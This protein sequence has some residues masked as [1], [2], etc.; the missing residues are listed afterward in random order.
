MDYREQMKAAEA[1]SS[2]WSGRGSEKSDTHLFWAGFLREVL[3]VK[4]VSSVA[5]FERL[6]PDGGWID[7]LVPDARL[8]VEQKSIGRDLDIPEPRR[9]QMVTPYQQ[10]R[11]YANSLTY[12]ERVRYIITCNFGT[13]RIYDL[14]NPKHESE[15]VEIAL[16]D[17]KD[18]LPSFS[19][20]TDPANSRIE[21]ERRVS[22]QAG[23]LIGKLYDLL[24]SQYHDPDSDET[25]HALNALC[26]R[27]VFCL[28]AEDSG[29]FG[30]KAMFADYLQGFQAGQMR[31]ALLELFKTLNTPEDERD[32]Y[33]SDELRAFPYVN[34][35]LF[36]D[37]ISIPQ[38]TDDIRYLLIKEISRATDWREISPTIFGGV[39]ESTLNP[40]TRRAGGMHYTSIEN[41]H[42]V[43]D[44]LFLDDL[45]E[46]LRGIIGSGLSNPTVAK[47]LKAFQAKIGSLNFLDPACGSGNFLT[48]TYLS[49]RKLENDTLVALQAVSAR[50]T[51]SIGQVGFAYE[52]E[53]G[54]YV[55]LDQF[56]GIEI[57]D[58]AVS[59]AN[60]ALWIAEL[61][62]NLESEQVIQRVID[63]LP[64]KDA[65]NI[66]LGNAL[67]M[68]WND[69][70]P[71]SQCDYI[72]GNP[73]F[74]GA[75]M[76]SKEQ[77]AEIGDVFEY[78]KNWG[79]VD[80]VA[81]WY[82]KA[83]DYID[84]YPVRAAFVS[85]NSIVQGEQVAPI[86]S[87][88]WD[89]GFR[90]DFAHNTFRWGSQASDAA[91]V[92]V[93][94]I[95]FSKLGGEKRLFH[96]SSPDA[97][98]ELQYPGRLN[99]YL[100]DAPDVFV[101]SQSKP[102]DNAPPRI[103]IGNKPIDG[104]HYLFTHE[105]MLAF[106][107]VEPQAQEY[108]HRWVGA[109][110]FLN[111]KERWVLWLGNLSPA[112]LL[113]LPKSRERVQAVR[114]FRLKSKS[115]PTNK[116]ASTPTRFHVENMPQGTSVLVPKVSSERRRYI[117]LGLIEP[118]TIASDLVFL[119]P[120]ASIYHF[121]VLHS[122]FHNA[123]MRTVAG[124][125]KSDYRYSGGM[126]YN[127]FPWPAPTDTHRAAI[128]QHAQAVLDARKLYPDMSL[129]K[130]YDPDNDYMFP[131]LMSAHAKLDRAVEDAYGVRF[132]GDEEAIVAHLFKLYAELTAEQ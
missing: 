30:K 94:I 81:G 39:F 129:A 33:L 26:V 112:E 74:L 35:G 73:P 97:V 77:K 40:E 71:A 120:Y 125:L 60:T 90:I 20:I 11:D 54:V 91:H 89:L 128:E 28:Y 51:E 64:L 7:V 50:K 105:E 63:D 65:A 109:E 55:T 115:T 32:P 78:S 58:F 119:I 31:T 116:I 98:P 103:G 57:N 37:V 93:V 16:V 52:D 48:E 95:G 99:A 53:L 104:G 111:N 1:F 10:A 80:Y 88:L 102:L 82:M 47:Q 107:D 22:I 14:D 44:P 122:Q 132:N 79:N 61:Q 46:E 72:M 6:T 92:Y 127:T 12:S 85:T 70:L 75:R 8:L 2:K 108:F 41:I 76:Q 67:R 15:F 49:L 18:N 62:A 113:Q 117:P 59:V 96:Y 42:K 34:G 69:V 87:P 21:K 38:I 114:E 27:I 83:A 101:W 45:K 130:M 24:E 13:F 19:F 4:D 126:V 66:A 86:W 100:A 3:G 17:L 43:I 110:E 106:L 131:E 23:E 118:T 56:H 5:E 121:G 68:D 29:L 123:W 9:Q 84:G 36:R 25:R 124:R